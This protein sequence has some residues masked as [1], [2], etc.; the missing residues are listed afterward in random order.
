MAPLVPTDNPSAFYEGTEGCGMQCANPM[1]TPDEHRQ[2][3]E[4]IAWAGGVC[5]AVNFFTV[6]SKR[7][8]YSRIHCMLFICLVFLL[9]K[10][11]H[12]YGLCLGIFP[13]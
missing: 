4:L 13:D 3:H 2:I 5:A 10:D 12:F 6:V 7:Y 1:F 9:S 8:T 11:F